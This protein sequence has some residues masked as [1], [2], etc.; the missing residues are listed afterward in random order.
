M[1]SNYITILSTHA[2]L[3]TLKFVVAV[4]LFVVWVAAPP[5]VGERWAQ[6]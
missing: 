1:P 2:E 4:R 3:K 6:R 5:S